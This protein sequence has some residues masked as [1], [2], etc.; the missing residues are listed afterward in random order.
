MLYLTY[1]PGGVDGAGAGYLAPITWV[2]MVDYRGLRTGSLLTC[3]GR[4]F[5][6]GGGERL[7][8]WLPLMALADSFFFL[9]YD[10]GRYCRGKDPLRGGEAPRR[11]RR[12][13]VWQA[14]CTPG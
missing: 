4:E 2:E 13:Q 5:W 11:G 10:A 12:R 7:S 14:R 3:C 9:F 6:T 8:D 1:R